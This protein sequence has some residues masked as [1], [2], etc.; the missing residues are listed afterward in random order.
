MLFATVIGSG[1]KGETL[2][3]GN[4]AVALLGNTMATAAILFVLIT[5]LGPISGAHF[6]PAVTLVFAIDGDISAR[7]AFAY[8]LAQLGGGFIGV[9]AAHSMFDHPLFE[10]GSKVRTG[11]GQWLGE[12]LATFALVLTIFG[13]IRH[14]PQWVPAAVAMVITAGYWWTS[15]TSFANPAITLARSLTDSFSGIRPADAPGFIAA[16]LAG[17]VVALGCARWLFGRTA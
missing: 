5:I 11:P 1:I 13:T 15:S 16:Q 2:A 7:D 9:L 10:L 4:I 3:G 14:R 12:A 8:V 6:N 17:A